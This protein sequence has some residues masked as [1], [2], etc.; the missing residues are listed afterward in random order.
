MCRFRNNVDVP[1]TISII[2]EFIRQEEVLI[3]THKVLNN[4]S[5]Y[6]KEEKKVTHLKILLS[7]L[8]CNGFSGA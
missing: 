6:L 7:A 3:E 5:E 2:H 8:R 1:E 4:E